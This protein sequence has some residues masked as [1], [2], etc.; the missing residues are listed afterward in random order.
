MQLIKREAKVK[1]REEQGKEREKLVNKK[2]SK[3]KEQGIKGER[4]EREK[5]G[6]KK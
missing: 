4:D 2:R 5:V 3:G 6:N 1:N